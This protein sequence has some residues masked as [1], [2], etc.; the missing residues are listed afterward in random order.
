MSAGAGTDQ[1]TAMFEQGFSEMAYN[2]LLSKMPDAVQDVVTFKVLETDAEQGSAV[3]AFVML[4]NDQPIYIPVIMSANNIKP[5]MIA[6]HKTLNVF[7]PLSKA[8]LEEVDKTA[9]NPMGEGIKTPDALYSDV[10]IRN[11]V[12]PP[13][14]GRYSYASL[15]PKMCADVARVFTKETL[16][17]CAAE[18]ALVLV[19]FLNRAP[20][21]VKVACTN[22]FKKR[23]TLL[24][25]A[26]SIYGTSAVLEALRP[27]ATKVAAKQLH[28]GGLWIADKDTEPTT[29]RRVFGD[30]ASEAY[31]GVK[32][33]GF[34]AKDDRPRVNVAVQEQPYTTLTEP[35]QAGIYT[36]FETDMTEHP[37]FV[38]PSPI[39]L[40]TD[41]DHYLGRSINK[42]DASNIR[43]T[44]QTGQRNNY[45]V[46]FPDGRYLS[47]LDNLAGRPSTIDDVAG[48]ALHSG[49]FKDVAT[50][51]KVG[52]GFFVRQVGTTFQ[53]TCPVDIKSVTTDSEGVRRLRIGGPA[54]YGE[55][56]VI[57]QPG[58]SIWMSKDSSVIGLPPDFAWVPLKEKQDNH[59][60]IQSAHDI[61]RLLGHAMTTAGVRKVTLKSAGASQFSVDGGP[62]M[63]FIPALRKVA[64]EL[65]LAVPTVETMLVKAAT[66][67]RVNFWVGS[68][69]RLGYAQQLFS[70]SAAAAPAEAP[71]EDPAAAEAAAM[72]QQAPQPPPPPSPSDLAAMEMQQQI[73]AEMQKLQEK[74]QMLASLTQRTQEIATGA[75]VMPTV[76]S[77]AMGAPPPSMNMATGAPAPGGAPGMGGA[78]PPG[79]DP[80]MQ[81]GAPP[82]GMDPAMM[83]AAPGGALPQAPGQP[84]DPNMDPSMQGQP[85][86]DPSMDPNMDPS[87]QGQQQPPMAMMGPDGPNAQAIESEVNPQ[88]LEQAAQLQSGDVFDAAAVAS[89]AQSPAL[90]ELIGQYLPNLEKAL[91]NLA[92]VLLTL[93]MQ[94]TKIQEELGDE[95]YNQLEE[96]LIN[97]FKTMGELVLKLSQGAHSIRGQYEHALA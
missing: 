27:V 61:S 58:S 14:T 46:V 93:W 80:S 23:P 25:Y 3:G 79:M 49:L 76:Q 65:V 41:A 68:T 37:A 1:A 9:M 31:A 35:R 38:M 45:L 81:G 95:T 97:T 29:F 96:N 32:R 73:D 18:P 53:A 78:P 83:G 84:M 13:L 54:F 70:K 90:K 52:K 11:V 40:F 64:T 10:D 86:M 69:T 17:K 89:L 8:W 39:N 47:G 50:A 42:A 48:G 33:K 15:E 5:L 43:R 6:Y 71:P 63:S 92:R 16:E 94:E 56:T 66:E 21:N 60:F 7:L 26:A 59:K 24:K 12:V 75:P 88:F 87:M 91:D 85:G 57:T 44:H 19:D 51:P 67:R 2:I 34:A 72:Q 62:A 74:A 30:K 28:G 77:Q 55:K 4:R 22:I 20:N 36:L 82:P